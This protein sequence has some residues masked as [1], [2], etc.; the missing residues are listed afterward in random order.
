[1]RWRRLYDWHGPFPRG[2]GRPGKD[3]NRTAHSGGRA[4]SRAVTS[5]DSRRCL[6][7]RG[8]SPSL[9]WVVRQSWRGGPTLVGAPEIELD[10]RTVHGQ[11]HSSRKKR[12]ALPAKGR[13]I[14]GMN[15]TVLEPK[16]LRPEIIQRVEAMD[17]ESLLV[18][19]RILLIVE[20]ERLW[21]DLSAEAEQDRC[22]EK[23]ERLPEI[24]RQARVELRKG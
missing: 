8:R 5:G 20:K 19:H 1:M 9:V 23:F 22:S 17:D 6:G 24:I 4:S 2:F 18:L 14:T 3:R 16:N 13:H 21:R 7:S 15:S 12:L 11:S 10:A